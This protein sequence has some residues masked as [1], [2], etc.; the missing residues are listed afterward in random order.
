MGFLTVARELL[1]NLAATAVGDLSGPTGMLG[2]ILALGTVVYWVVTGHVRHVP[3]L[4]QPGTIFGW[5][6][7]RRF[8]QS[9]IADRK[10]RRKLFASEQFRL[11]DHDLS[12][13]PFRNRSV[14]N[15]AQ[16]GE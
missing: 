4:D 11:G 5:N 3:K 15:F 12:M 7:C 13:T 9:G 2:Y 10:Q 8:K 1:V 14:V 16:I 6:D